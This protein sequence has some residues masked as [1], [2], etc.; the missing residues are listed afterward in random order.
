[1]EVLVS[2]LRTR[3][4]IALSTEH[5]ALLAPWLGNYLQGKYRSFN[6]V[7]NK[8][9]VRWDEQLQ[10]SITGS[11]SDWFEHIDMIYMPMIWAD[12]HWVGLAINLGV[13]TVDILD[14]NLSLYNDRKVERFIAPIVELLPYV[15]KKFCTGPLSQTHDLKPFS[16]QR[17]KG[18]YVNDRSGDCGPLAMKLLEIY[19]HGGGPEQMAQISD[20]IVDEFMA[21]YAL[22]IYK[23][24]VTPIYAPPH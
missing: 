17:L 8:D 10:R 14:P 13:W 1:M 19:I 18:I 6:A 9:R 15:I 22:D 7:K 2:F 16:W 4:S 21:Q 24:L 23:G 5:S 3:H 12:A 11:P 20:D